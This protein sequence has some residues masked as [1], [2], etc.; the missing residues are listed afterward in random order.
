MD[1][2]D[3]KTYEEFH[4]DVVFTAK[5]AGLTVMFVAVVAALY[6]P[7]AGAVPLGRR[8]HVVQALYSGL[9]LALFMGVP[10]LALYILDPR[11][12][13]G[14]VQIGYVLNLLTRPCVSA[15][16]IYC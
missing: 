10:W 3:G 9:A 13:G 11:S 8:P 7:P 2:V 6:R 4:K 1:D 15:G 5:W 12:V 16:H 14:I